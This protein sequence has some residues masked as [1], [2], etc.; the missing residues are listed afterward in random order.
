MVLTDAF[1]VR[2]DWFQCNLTSMDGAQ[3]NPCLFSAV[4]Q[5]IKEIK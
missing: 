2:A 1:A 5:G 4:E 3:Q